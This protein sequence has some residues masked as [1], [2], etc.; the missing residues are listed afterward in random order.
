MRLKS[1]PAIGL[2]A[3]AALSLTACDAAAS[4]DS[5]PT[6]TI[7]AVSSI[8]VPANIA[9]ACRTDLKVG[10]VTI[11]LQALFFNQINTG[12]QTIADAAGVDLQLVSANDD[13][14]AQVTAVEQ[15][16]TQ[17]MDAI[18]ILP[19]D[20]EGIKPAIDAAAEANIPVVVVDG[21]VD[22]SAIASAV[23][24][25]NAESSQQL[26]EYLATSTKTRGEIGIVGA[27]NSTIQLARQKGFIDQA[28]SDGFAE[29]TIVDGKNV[30][31]TAQSAAE[32]L[33]TANPTMGFAFAT[34]EP[35]LI[36]LAAAVETQ[37]AGDRVSVVGW[38]LSQAA[39]AGLEEGWLKAIVQQ[40]T[41]E[42]GYE[43]MNAAINAAC[44][45]PT[46]AFVPIA[47]QIVTP[48]NY[49]DF[50]YYLER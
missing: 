21:I 30:Q 28:I 27:L 9:T 45:E 17:E 32:N 16:I 48:E 46:D 41:Y 26:A 12:A 44:G 1:I 18:I 11:N 31:E 38:D 8:P 40:N 29:G 23:G 49:S 37:N 47:T 4:R 24:T 35:A 3:L 14:L 5:A 50:L 33:L 34:G 13:P 10:L 25:A 22:S 2:V 7:A 39:V 19:I 42:F 20:T 15:F 6:A 43:G 36:G